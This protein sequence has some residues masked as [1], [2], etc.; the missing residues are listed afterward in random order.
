MPPTRNPS[1]ICTEKA[2]Q[3]ILFAKEEEPFDTV[4]AENLLLGLLK[5]SRCIAAKAL[6][7]SNIEAAIVR[8]IVRDLHAIN[9]PVEN[10]AAILDQAFEEAGAL[11]HNYIGTEHLLLALSTDPKIAVV[12][13]KLAVEPKCVR[14]AMLRLLGCPH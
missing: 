6:R 4:C 8:N 1:E 3:A 13:D 7:H 10:L 9:P 12:L 11:G 2:I 5:D 14:S